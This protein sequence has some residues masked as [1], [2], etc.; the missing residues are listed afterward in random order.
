MISRSLRIMESAF[1]YYAGH[2]DTIV[3]KRKLSAEAAAKITFLE[4]KN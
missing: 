2:T 3:S 4:E 1:K